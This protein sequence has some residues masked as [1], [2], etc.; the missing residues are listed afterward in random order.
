MEMA[1]MNELETGPMKESS[2]TRNQID[3]RSL[4]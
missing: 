4:Y 3:G 2:L 1:R